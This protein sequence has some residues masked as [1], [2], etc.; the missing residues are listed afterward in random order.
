MFQKLINVRLTICLQV[1]QILAEYRIKAKLYH[2]DKQLQQESTPAETT[3]ADTHSDISSHQNNSSEEA[4]TKLRTEQ[5]KRL[6]EA[7]EVLCDQDLRRHYDSWRLSG[8]CMSFKVWKS[9]RATN[10]V[11]RPLSIVF[12]FFHQIH[13]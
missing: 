11:R 7:K 9:L 5:F 13:S 8:L 3:T 2:P 1:E 12:F 6:V 10:H 4:C